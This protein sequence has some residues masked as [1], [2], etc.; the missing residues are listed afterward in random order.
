ME[1]VSYKKRRTKT[2]RRRTKGKTKKRDENKIKRGSKHLQKNF[3]KETVEEKLENEDNKKKLNKEAIQV[4]DYV[5]VNFE[6]IYFP[7]VVKSTM[8][9]S[10][11]NKWKW[12]QED[13]EIWY[14]MTKLLVE[15]RFH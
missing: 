11:E 15:L 2:T 4:G 14:D 10:G 1:G 3:Q 9:S 5:I 13:D 8:T 7:G 12:P 6:G